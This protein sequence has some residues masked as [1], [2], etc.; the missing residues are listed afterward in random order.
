MFKKILFFLIPL[1]FCTVVFFLSRSWIHSRIQAWLTD[2][3]KAN[4]N[5]SVQYEELQLSWSDLTRIRALK[6]R[7]QTFDAELEP[8][9]E[10]PLAELQLN[11]R[12]L[13]KGRFQ[14]ESVRFEQAS[15]FL[16]SG[17]LHHLK[18]RYEALPAD[19][20][21]QLAQGI[22]CT[23]C[24]VAFKSR[25]FRL[26]PVQR[27]ERADFRILKAP[28]AEH[29]IN[30]SLSGFKPDSNEDFFAVA[31][32]DVK[33]DQ[34]EL[35][36]STG[37]ETLMFEGVL[38][39]VSKTPEIRGLIEV[40]S[41]PL[42][43]QALHDQMNL[44]GSL[45]G[46]FRISCEGRSFADW[47][48]SLTVQGTMDVR[49]GVW[50][51]RNLL[52]ETIAPAAES[53]AAESVLQQ[54]PYEKMFEK[55][56]LPFERFF[57][58]FQVLDQELLVSEFQVFGSGY[59]IELQ[60]NFDRQSREADFSGYSVLLENTAKDTVLRLPPLQERLNS[61]GRLVVPFIYRGIEPFAEVK[62]DLDTAEVSLTRL[63][64]NP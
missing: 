28:G 41:Y 62:P 5:L 58:D 50:S 20:R 21:P 18:R 42:E 26:T 57:I 30:A 51:G 33:N 44:S 14:V 55:E 9:A 63:Q 54:P 48:S 6:V 27:L 23:G 17:R 34:A 10:A 16:D 37:Q 43:G 4:W 22:E 12:E 15:V 45:T 11:S 36:M 49:D 61:Q 47:R 2:D 19:R 39:N 40:L 38:A 53:A 64:T 24:Q 25:I 31:F 13:V 29:V 46:E 35:K 56:R 32:Y 60:G 1:L 3:L 52:L 7:V 59:V 8:L